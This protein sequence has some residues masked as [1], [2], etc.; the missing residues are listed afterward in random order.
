MRARTW[1]SVV[2]DKL[3]LVDVLVTCKEIGRHTCGE[4]L[5]AEEWAELEYLAAS[6]N[7]V[8]RKPKPA[9]LPPT[10]TELRLM[11]FK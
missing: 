3:L 8:Q 9:W 5:E 10:Q 2:K 11:G 6:D 1:L 7:P 4:V